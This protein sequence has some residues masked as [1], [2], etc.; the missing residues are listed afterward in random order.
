[1]QNV[2][3]RIKS[4]HPHGVSLSRVSQGGLLELSGI[5]ALILLR[6]AFLP[7]GEII[8]IIRLSLPFMT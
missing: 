1:M 2:E 3:Q 6:R 8:V 7:D 4:V 5:V